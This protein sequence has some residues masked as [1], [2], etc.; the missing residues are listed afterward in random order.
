[1]VGFGS[2]KPVGAINTLRP[3][4]IHGASTIAQMS[5]QRMEILAQADTEKFN[6]VL[7][8][9]A[10][11]VLERIDARLQAMQGKTQNV[12]II[13]ARLPDMEG[14]WEILIKKLA[15]PESQATANQ[16][17][18]LT[19]REEAFD[20]DELGEIAQQKMQRVKH[21]RAL[22]RVLR[23]KGE[24]AELSKV[25]GRL[26]RLVHEL[27]HL[28]ATITESD[29]SA[30]MGGVM[31]GLGI[32]KEGLSRAAHYLPEIPLGQGARMGAQ[33]LRRVG[34]AGLG[35]RVL[36]TQVAGGVLGVI[37]IPKTIVDLAVNGQRSLRIK[38]RREQDQVAMD[39]VEGSHSSDASSFVRSKI[40]DTREQHLRRQRRDNIMDSIKNSFGLAAASLGLASGVGAILTTVGVIAA[41]SLVASSLATLGA[42]SGGIGGVILLI[43]IAY[44]L[45]THR[46]YLRQYIPDQIRS[47]LN[48]VQALPIQVAQ[49]CQKA[50]RRIA[51]ALRLR[52][53]DLKEDLV[54]SK[55]L[56]ELKQE[57]RRITE[58][59]NFL[60]MAQA[61]R[62][63][64]DD[65]RELTTGI[66]TELHQDEAKRAATLD[67]L[68][69]LGFVSDAE[70]TGRLNDADWIAERVLEFLMTHVI[71]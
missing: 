63:D 13:V 65:L 22:R 2:V 29:A 28:D 45:S 27:Q 10:A 47:V 70:K 46:N 24:T 23:R 68:N 43:G 54:G 59:L 33:G 38:E 11:A 16:R 30:T 21:L 56:R 9:R 67:Y 61:L 12:E 66:Q 37:E 41:T 3:L 1:M 69:H 50:S 15:T 5:A 14:S 52:S 42:V 31:Q 8:E 35:T 39:S 55:R 4:A 36:P 60:E 32:V 44:F 18:P 49:G 51:Q 17:V 40:H 26:A 7:K 34:A 64:W 71:A 25:N 62:M 53:A 57:K 48:T 6:A 58:R 20:I 19:V